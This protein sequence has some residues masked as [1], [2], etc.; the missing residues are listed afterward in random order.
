MRHFILFCLVLLIISCKNGAERTVETGAKLEVHSWQIS[1]NRIAVAS[2]LR[3]D[4]IHADYREY[5]KYLGFKEEPYFFIIYSTGPDEVH[6]MTFS[7]MTRFSILTGR[8]FS[9][10]LRSV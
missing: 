2:R 3:T 8:L 6:E 7:D 10:K 4:L 5:Y 1:T 9:T